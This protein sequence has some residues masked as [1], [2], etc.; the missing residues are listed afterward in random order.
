VIIRFED[1]DLY[2]IDHLLSDEE[3]MVRDSVKA[4][5]RDRVM[6][7]IEEWAWE[8]VFPRHLV[9]EMGDLHLL[10]ASFSEYD[11][12]SLSSVAYGL[13]CQELERGDSGIRSFVSVQNSLVMFPILMWGTQDQKDHWIPKLGSGERIGCFGLT[14]P[15]FG[16]NPGAMRTR[17]VREGDGW[18]LNGEKAW[19][20]NGSI[21][22]VA[23]VWA[24][25]EEGIRGFLVERGTP[26]FSTP[27]HKGKYSLRVSVT[28]QLVF[29]DCRLPAEGLLPGTTGLKN[30]LKC[31]TQARYGIA[32]GAIGS[33]MATFTAALNYAKSRIQFGDRPIATRQNEGRRDHV[34]RRGVAGQAQQ[35]VGG[36]GVRQAR[37]GDPRSQ[38][39]R[40]RVSNHA[41]PHEHRIGPHI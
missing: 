7:D 25:T 18:I 8:G 24:R 12:A 32:W 1:L 16:S 5:V 34:S 4:W 21:A 22:D 17:A 29:G 38:R 36:A 35:R 20:T 9:K 19:I 14:E 27:D 26:G 30:P 33:A 31:L 11:L 6:P 37:P 28:S 23:V 40:Q 39:D 13:I 2:H 3:R 15:D 10:G 41:P